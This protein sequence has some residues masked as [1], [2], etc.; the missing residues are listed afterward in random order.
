M[1]MIED[2]ELGKI[3]LPQGIL[4]YFE[5]NKVEQTEQALQ[6]YLEEK[7]IIPQEYQGQKLT[8]KGFFEEIKVQDFPIRGKSVYLLIRRRR[9]LNE[10][11]GS[12]VFRDWALISKGTRMTNEFGAFLKAI[13]RYQ[14]G[15]L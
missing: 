13:Y 12:I 5:L 14:S 15:Q 3:I 8:S 9:W 6:F 7:K 4:D 10:D 11:T 2:K 1:Q